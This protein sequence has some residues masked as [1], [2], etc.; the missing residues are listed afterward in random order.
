M[1]LKPSL[2]ALLGVGFIAGCPA[3]STV[4]ST[5][6]QPTPPVHALPT[7]TPCADDVGWSDPTAP[8]H[9][10]GT[11]WF[12][13]TCSISAILVTSP[14]GH[15]LIDAATEQAATTIEA[16]IRALGFRVEDIRVIL[17]THEHNDHAGGIARLQRDSGARVLARADAARA[18]AEGKAG[19][20]D[21]Q[22]GISQA[23]P[24][25]AN[26]HAM[27]DGEVVAVGS[28]RITNLPSPG[29]TRGGSGW[30][31]RS[32]EGSTCR[33]IVFADS[34]TAL[35]DDA[36]RYSDR[37]GL[38]TA[39]RDGLAHVGALPCDI[40]VTTH[41]QASDL[42]ARLDGNAPLVNA[43]ACEAHAERGLAGLDK[44]LADER[45]DRTP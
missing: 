33:D 9:V 1:K 25:V 14:Q 15:I 3:P 4:A 19:R 16:N 6:P 39:F 8:R 36:F 5:T 41:V 31:W 38:V 37:P 10:F 30:T 13:G 40:L 27:V 42:L 44:R 17:N 34:A 20:D 18:L 23:F 12:V 26:V 7:P 32:C 21:P 22:F 28:L 29:H 2:V 43:D 35:S 11:T 45:K 24:P